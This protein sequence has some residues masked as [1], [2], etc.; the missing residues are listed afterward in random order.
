MRLNLLTGFLFKK[1]FNNL[2]PASDYSLTK[3][4]KDI[5]WGCKKLTKPSIR[6]LTYAL[7][8]NIWRVR[9]IHEHKALGPTVFKSNTQRK[10]R[11]KDRSQRL[12]YNSWINLWAT[13]ILRDEGNKPHRSRCLITQSSQKHPITSVK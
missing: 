6:R 2:P 9:I 4:N 3:Q 8:H 12:K 1:Y 5:D 11:L 10:E 7:K 13:L